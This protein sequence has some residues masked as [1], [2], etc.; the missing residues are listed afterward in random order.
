M[1]TTIFKVTVGDT[2]LFELLDVDE[3][4]GRGAVTGLDHNMTQICDEDPA[5]D[6]SE[7]RLFGREARVFD[8]KFTADREHASVLEAGGFSLGHPDSMPVGVQAAVVTIGNVTRN[9]AQACVTGCHSRPDTKRT[10]TDY[11]LKLSGPSSPP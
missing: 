8:L 3:R 11:S 5:I 1:A 7:M 9:F 4:C 2:T 10:Y 6:A